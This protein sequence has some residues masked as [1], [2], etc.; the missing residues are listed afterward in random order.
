MKRCAIILFACFLFSAYLSAQFRN[1]DYR[2]EFFK[3]YGPIKHMTTIVYAD[4]KEWK[5]TVEVFDTI[6]IT[7]SYVIGESGVII[8]SSQRS[9]QYTDSNSCLYFYHKN[10]GD[11]RGSER[12][13]DTIMFYFNA[14]GDKTRAY[15]MNSNL[16]DSFVYD[17]HGRLIEKYHR[18]FK[19]GEMKLKYESTYDSLGRL[20]KEKCNTPYYYRSHRSLVK[21]KYLPNGNYKRYYTVNG[22]R[23]FVA[24]CFVNDKGQLVKLKFRDFEVLFSQHD[25]YGNWLKYEMTPTRSDSRTVP[26]VILRSIEYFE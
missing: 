21:Y 23:R 16:V 20:V 8:R 15:D 6:G 11:I 12:D 25:R 24:E 10:L 14:K 1:D 7:E 4:G 9:Y 22:V 19:T 5:R 13:E 2:G 18:D 26:A 3:T 17:T